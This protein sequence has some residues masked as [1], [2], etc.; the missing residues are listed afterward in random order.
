M[1]NRIA[2]GLWLI[3]DPHGEIVEDILR[4]LPEMARN[5]AEDLLQISW[6]SLQK[7]GYEEVKVEIWD[8]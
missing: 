5:R 4:G 8:I 6:D 7:M 2:I 1:S 3:R